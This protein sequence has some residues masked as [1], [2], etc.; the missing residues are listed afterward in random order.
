MTVTE[1]ANEVQAQLLTAFVSATAK[2]TV[3][4]PGVE[5][6]RGG[7]ALSQLVISQARV[8]RMLGTKLMTLPLTGPS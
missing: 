7:E 5:S 2:I 6:S 8:R 3:P 4:F 1:I